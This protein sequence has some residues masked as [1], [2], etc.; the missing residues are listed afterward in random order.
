MRQRLRT[1]VGPTGNLAARLGQRREGATGSPAEPRGACRRRRDRRWGRCLSHRRQ[2]VVHPLEAK[3]RLQA[4]QRA[5]STATTVLVVLLHRPN[6]STC[7]Y[8]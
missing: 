7:A 1:V 8:L 6:L 5:D 4:I 2:L 3:E